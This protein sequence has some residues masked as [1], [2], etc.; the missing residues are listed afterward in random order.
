MKSRLSP[1]TQ[2]AIGRSQLSGRLC[3]DQ[4]NDN[5]GPMTMIQFCRQHHGRPDFGRIGAR[6]SANYDV[7]GLQRPSLSC[8]SNRLRDAAVASARSASDQ[9]S[10]HSTGRSRPRS[11]S[12][13]AQSRILRASSGGSVRTTSMSDS[14]LALRTIS[15]LLYASPAGRLAFAERRKCLTDLG[16]IGERLTLSKRSRLCNWLQTRDSPKPSRDRDEGALH[17]EY[18]IIPKTGMHPSAEG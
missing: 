10:D 6:K 7:A 17:C 11:P 9:E 18:A 3:G 1:V 2:L 13:R 4:A 12:C 16:G 8:S 14:S 5:V 15:P